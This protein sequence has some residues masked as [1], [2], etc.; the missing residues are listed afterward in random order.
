MKILHRFDRIQD[1]LFRT[2]VKINTIVTGTDGLGTDT[3]CLPILQGSAPFFTDI[4]RY[5]AWDPIVDYVGASSYSGTSR[6]MIN[7]YKLPKPNLVAG[8]PV[9]LFDDIL[10]SGNTID[11][12]VKTCYTLGATTVIPVV[13][14]KRKSTPYVQDPRVPTTISVYEIDN[15]WVWGYGMDD[16]HGKG[17]TS[18]HIVYHEPNAEA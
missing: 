12:F 5:F 14:L 8:K 9:L 3:V 10:D 11:Y 2:A 13:L 17:R 6:Q 7:A 18:K 4:S 1:E 15:E 16:I